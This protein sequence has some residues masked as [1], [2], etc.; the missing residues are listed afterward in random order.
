MQAAPAFLHCEHTGD[1]PSHFMISSISHRIRSHRIRRCRRHRLLKASIPW[2]SSFGIS[3]MQIWFLF[4][5]GIDSDP[6]ILHQ[7]CCLPAHGFH[8]AHS[9]LYNE[10]MDSR[11]F[12]RWDCGGISRET[13]L[14]EAGPWWR[15]ASRKWMVTLDLGTKV[16]Y[17]LQ[18]FVSVAEIIM[19]YTSLW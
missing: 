10:L 13:E 3:N 6:Q 16:T 12:W 15:K 19:D 8:P 18:N 4:L 7:V 14:T 2:S 11:F 17:F 1:A 9:L 5:C